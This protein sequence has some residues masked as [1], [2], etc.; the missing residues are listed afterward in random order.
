MS[1]PTTEERLTP[2]GFL[3]HCPWLTATTIDQPPILSDQPPIIPTFQETAVPVSLRFES[4]GM[5]PM[6][7][8]TAEELMTQQVEVRN[9]TISMRLF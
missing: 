4:S 5:P 7:V 1:L 6:V 2:R 3:K 8:A 9:C